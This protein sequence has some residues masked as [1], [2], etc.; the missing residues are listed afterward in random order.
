VSEPQPPGAQQVPPWW[1]DPTEN[2]KDNLESERRRADDLREMQAGYVSQIG[3]MREAHARYVA[4]L[5]SDHEKELRQLRSSHEKELRE[6]ESKR[7]DAIRAVDVGNVAADKVVAEARANTLAN[8]VATTAE[9]FR[10]S[11]ASELAPIKVSIEDL[12]RAQYQTQGEKQQVVETREVR[13]ESRLNQGQL[14][15]YAML[16]LVILGLILAYAVKK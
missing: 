11:I 9:T 13:G 14:V 12:R 10:A 3:E 2:V 5:R 8:Q 6:A 1:T 16:A 15:S 7:I 4:E